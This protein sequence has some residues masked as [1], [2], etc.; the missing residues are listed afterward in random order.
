MCLKCL[1]PLKSIR[2]SYDRW[3]LIIS[4]I[5]S[6]QNPCNILQ[7]NWLPILETTLTKCWLSSILILENWVSENKVI[8]SFFMGTIQLDKTYAC[9]WKIKRNFEIARGY[10]ICFS[11]SGKFSNFSLR[12]LIWSRSQTLAFKKIFAKLKFSPALFEKNPSFVCL[13]FKI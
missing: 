11:T 8:W 9:F 1:F 2:E 13:V 7:K 6:N 10:L 12:N 5:T 3:I 4:D